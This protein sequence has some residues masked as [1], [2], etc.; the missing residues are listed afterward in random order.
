VTEPF[1]SHT[2]G[3]DDWGY[4]VAE[5]DAASNYE[6]KE[7][8]DSV[9]E[10]I[11]EADFKTMDEL[12]T[13]DLSDWCEACGMPFALSKIHAVSD[14]RLELREHYVACLDKFQESA[15]KVK[16]MKASGTAT[17]S[18]DAVIE[19]WGAEMEEDL[20]EWRSGPTGDW[21]TSEGSDMLAAYERKIQSKWHC[22][23]VRLTLADVR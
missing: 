19:S 4:T 20:V 12:C 2:S 18:D 6:L 8:Q 3:V 1:Q 5:S 9:R 7:D 11:V 14:R 16:A 22:S 10:E 23:C 15:A 13:C 21:N 17:P